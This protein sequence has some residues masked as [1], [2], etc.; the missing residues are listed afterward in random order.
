M[1]RGFV[2]ME[3]DVRRQLRTNCSLGVGF[4]QLRDCDGAPTVKKAG[5]NNSV[6]E[7]VRS[8]QERFSTLLKLWLSR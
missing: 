8:L 4:A 2:A 3:T 1:L 6:S 5:M 7:M